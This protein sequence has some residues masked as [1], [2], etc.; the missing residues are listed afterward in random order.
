MPT[1]ILIRNADLADGTG[2]P[3]RRADI[4]VQNGRIAAISGPGEQDPANA[5]E[6]I[7]AEGPRTRPR[8][9][10]PRGCS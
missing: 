3:L 10:R 9:S 8:S 1:D 6:V 4:A 7:E 5:A 2:D